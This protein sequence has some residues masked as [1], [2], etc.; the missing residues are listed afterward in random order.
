LGNSLRRV[1]LS[2][3]PGAAITSVKIAVILHEFSTIPG[4][5]ED[6]IQIMLNLKEVALKVEDAQ[7]L[8]GP[9][10]L[11]I[12]R[13]G[14]GEITAGDIDCPPNIKVV[15]PEAHIA[16]LNDESASLSM[17]MTAEM[18]EGYVPSE[19][20]AKSR[21]EWPL[22]MIHLDAIF[23]PVTKVNFIVEPTRVGQMRDGER[24]IL[25]VWTNGAI[26]P[27]EAVKKSARILSEYLQ[28]FTEFP[29]EIEE[30][31]PEE[32][33]TTKE[34]ILLNK[35][36]D[37]LNFSARTYN[38]LKRE[39]ITTLRE[40]LENTEEDLLAIKNFGRKSLNE[41]K[42]KLTELNLALREPDKP[43]IKK[44]NRMTKEEKETPPEEKESGKDATP[45]ST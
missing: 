40:L 21:H 30:E 10:R 43:E 4:V 19:V 28:V 37:E 23:T 15:N 20:I 1:L 18:G 35:F 31:V 5:V 25:E 39:N 27:D 26:E 9:I 24:L 14:E 42:D 29:R 34:E 22:G 3:I 13:R 33:P 38:C 44:R 16:T 36:I 45:Q 17:R 41:L 2:S 7:E 8:E 32:V 6:V 11:K 12:E